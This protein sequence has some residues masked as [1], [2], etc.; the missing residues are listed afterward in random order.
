MSK[1][2]P[3]KNAEEE[4]GDSVVSEG[5]EEGIFLCPISFYAYFS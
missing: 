3:P 4:N 1:Y 2:V 5:K